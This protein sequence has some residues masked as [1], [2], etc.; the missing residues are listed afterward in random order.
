VVSVSQTSL[1]GAFMTVGPTVVYIAVMFVVVQPFIRLAVSWLEKFERLDQAR[2]A[3]IFIG[4]LLSALA[5]EFIGIH[6]IFGAFLFGAVVP[7]S[8]RV[9]A[10]VSA[11]LEGSTSASISARSRP[12]CSR[13]W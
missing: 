4:V 11:R 7:H 13:C 6:A 5:T 12:G 10:D 3:A 2:L 8:S 1:A 9:A